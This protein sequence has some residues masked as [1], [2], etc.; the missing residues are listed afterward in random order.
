M[1]ILEEFHLW[2]V[3]SAQHFYFSVVIVIQSAQLTVD[4]VVIQLLLCLDMSRLRLCNTCFTIMILLHIKQ[5]HEKKNY[6]WFAQE[7]QILIA[8][9]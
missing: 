1:P 7:P 9:A 2:G 5:S 3:A 8:V 4:P 6:L